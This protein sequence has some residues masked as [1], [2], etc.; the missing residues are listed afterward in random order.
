MT[1][2]D[3][4]RTLPETTP[5]VDANRVYHPEALRRVLAGIM[6]TALTLNMLGLN[7]LLPTIGVILQL[8]GFRALR[9]ENRWFKGCYVL[10]IIRTAYFF[11]SVVLD[12]TI[13]RSLFPDSPAII[14]LTVFNLVLMLAELILLRGGLLALRRTAGLSDSVSGAAALIIWYIAICVLGLLHCSGWLL[15]LPMLAAYI[16]I[17]YRLYGNARALERVHYRIASVPVKLMDGWVVLSILAAVLIFGGLGYHFGSSYPMHWTSNT[18]EQSAEVQDISAHLTKLGFPADVLS[19]LSAEDIAALKAAQKVISQTEDESISTD[20]NDSTAAADYKNLRITGVGVQLDEDRWIV[21]HHFR[22]LTDMQ[23]YGTESILLWP[24]YRTTYNWIADGDT[25]GRILCDKG[26]QTLTADYYSLDT[27]ETTSTSFFGDAQ[28]SL[29][30][31][32]AFSM[33]R[34]SSNQRGYLLYPVKAAEPDCLLDSWINYTHQRTWAQFPAMTAAEKQ[35]TGWNGGAFHT[36][37]TALQFYPE[38]DVT[39]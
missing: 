26:D 4:A 38:D 13:L 27:Q 18:T 14:V 2:M 6:L 3:T 30:T 11:S 15:M 8:L 7:Y 31:Y 23:Y 20:P 12:T 33:P 10:S 35:A 32:A 39:V 28:T 22:W 34:G 19:D 29:D 9:N 21:I 17:I 1:D 36:V 24:T 5:P 25:T 16:I 37:Q